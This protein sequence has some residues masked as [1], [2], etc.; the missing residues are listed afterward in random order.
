M[1]C[2]GGEHEGVTMNYIAQL[3]AADL[4]WSEE[5]DQS[6]KKRHRVDLAPT[7]RAYI[8][9]NDVGNNHI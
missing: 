6:P 4:R 1:S 9:K 8:V 5:R 7:R 3:Q 2:V